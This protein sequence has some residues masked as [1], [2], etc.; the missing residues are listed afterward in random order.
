MRGMG[1]ARVA[2]SNSNIVRS[3]DLAKNMIMLA[4]QGEADSRDDGCMVL[5]GVVRDCAYKIQSVAER[6]RLIHQS[7]GQWRA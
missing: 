5:Y 1:G 7:S 6:E 2:A 3:L 4:T